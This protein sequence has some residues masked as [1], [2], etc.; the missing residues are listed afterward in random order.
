MVHDWAYFFGGPASLKR[1]ADK[2]LYECVKPALGPLTAT[3]IWLGVQVG[4]VWWLPYKGSRWGYGYAY[5][6]YG[7][8]FGE[9]E[10]PPI[11]ESALALDI[12]D[13]L[14]GKPASYW[15]R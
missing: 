3:V 2:V 12:M 5:P 7:P 1:K 6:E 4:G 10:T 9:W 15:D 8:Q 13:E 14:T 11:T